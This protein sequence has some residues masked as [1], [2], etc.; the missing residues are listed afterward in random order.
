L[1]KSPVMMRHD[2]LSV[3]PCGAGQHINKPSTQHDF[4][5]GTIAATTLRDLPDRALVAT[6]AY[7]FARITPALKMDAK[8]L[9]PRG[10]GW[11]VRLHKKGGKRPEIG[12]PC[13]LPP[14][15]HPFDCWAGLLIS[16]K[17]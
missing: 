3:F 5:A 1:C 2:G 15:H 10:A 6:L 17:G 4:S 16:G 8:D 9:R 12:P 13:R 14:F 7:S 11:T